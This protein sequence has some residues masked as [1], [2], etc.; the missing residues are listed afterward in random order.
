MC[1]EWMGF[2]KKKRQS[3]LAKFQQIGQCLHR[4]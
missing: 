4:R 2:V 3:S 1:D